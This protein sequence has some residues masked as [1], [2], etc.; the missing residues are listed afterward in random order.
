MLFEDMLPLI[1]YYN[2]VLLKHLW[3]FRYIDFII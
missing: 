1:W 3:I 2:I